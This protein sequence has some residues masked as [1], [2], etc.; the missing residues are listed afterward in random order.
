MDENSVIT[1]TFGD[2]AENH[3]GMQKIGTECES[4][5]NLED[6]TLFKEKMEE[7]GCVCELIK[8]NLENIKTKEDAYVLII[9]DGVN[10]ILGLKELSK[11]DMFEEQLKLNID[12]K[13]LMYGRVVNKNARWNLC[14]DLQPQEPDYTNGKGRIISYDEVPITKYF[15]EQLPIIFGH[16]AEN[17]KIEGNYY[18]DIKKCGI[19]F[20]GDAERRIVIGVRLGKNSPPLHFQWFKQSQPVEERIILKINDG[21]INFMSEKATGNDWKSKKK[22]KYTLRHATGADKFTTI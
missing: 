14:F 13:A 22:F 1:L 20:H 12:K 2:C 6:L 9:R 21:E 19:G 17:L 15:Y 7:F 4:G 11:I 10:A 8:L 16:K 18:Y 5:F 3:V